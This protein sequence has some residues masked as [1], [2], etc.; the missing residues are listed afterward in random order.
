MMSKEKTRECTANGWSNYLPHCDVRN[1]PPVQV[2]DSVKVLSTSYDEEYSVGQVVRFECKDPSLKLNGP[3]EIYCTSEGEWNLKPPTCA[4][5]SCQSPDI[6]NGELNNQRKKVYK[7]L[8]VMQFTCKRGFRASKNGESTCTK[9]DWNPQPSCTEIVCSRYQTVENGR[10]DGEQTEY[11]FDQEIDV[12]CDAGYVIQQEPNTRRKCTAN[13]WFPPTKCVSKS[14]D[15]P[16]IEHGS[17]Y[18]WYWFPKNNGEYIH[19]RCETNYLPRHWTRIDCTNTGWNP[20]PKCSRLCTYR[21]AFVENAELSNL[22]SEY[23]EGEKVDFQCDDNFITSD[24][25]SKGHRTCLSNGKFTPAKCSRTCKTPEH[26]NAQFT[27]SKKEYEIGEYLQYEC[28]KGYMT[29]SRNLLGRAQCLN[30]RW[31]ETPQCIAITCEHDGVSY[32]DGEVAEFTCPQGQRSKTDFGQCFYY[33]WGP[34]PSCQYIQCTIQKTPG[35]VLSP[36][37]KYYKIYDEVQFSCDQGLTRVGSSRSVCTEKDW[38]QPIPTCEDTEDQAGKNVENPLEPDSIAPTPDPKDK[39]DNG[40]KCPLAYSPKYAEI[41]NPKKAYY[42]ND[43]VTFQCRK[44]YKMFGS[45]TIQCIKGKWEHPPECIQLKPCRNPPA[46]ISD[47]SL[48]D[49]SVREIYVT[50]DVVKYVCKR[51]FHIS[52]SDQSTCINGLWTALPTC[53]ENSCDE[54]PEVINA[55]II[56]KKQ[57]YNHLEKAKY[58]CDSGLSFTGE[59]S[60]LCLEGQWTDTPS[61]VDKSCGPPQVVSNSIIKEQG[62]NRYESGEKV[63]YLCIT[64]YSLVGSGEAF[65]KN[66]V[67]D[68]KPVCKR[69]GSECGPP[70][71]VQYGD[72]LETRKSAYKS[73]ETVTYKCPQYYKL[74][75]ESK[76]KCENGVWDKAPECIEPCTAKEKDMKENN[77]KLRHLSDKKL[78]SE[79]GDVIEFQCVSGFGVP[80]D[81]K[82]RIYC[83][84]GKLE[85]PKCYKRGFCVLQQPTMMANNII[86]NVSTVVD[87]GQTI[88]FQCNEG[89]TAETQLQAKCENQNINYPRCTSAKSCKNPTIQN[90]FIKTAE[91]PR[92]DSGSYVEFECNKDY[93]LYGRMSA[94]CVNGEWEDLP[95]CYAPCKILV[96]KL[97]KH[98]IRLLD[99]M[100][101]MSHTHGTEFRAECRPGFK[102]PV[103][104]A[105]A[106]ECIDGMF[107]YPTCF[108]GPTC[109]M[110]QDQLD[111][112]NLELDE[113]HESAVYYGE[114][115]EIRFKCKAEFKYRGQP[116][117]KCSQ[118]KITYPKCEGESSV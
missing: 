48:A 20:E 29:Q 113:V 24:G 1:C 87:D 72:T 56:E 50:D 115:A 26:P 103:Q 118:K 76:V 99:A 82:M 98:N 11:K 71:H 41:L 92:Y 19:Y 69:T 66:A 16:D 9:N 85:Y 58:I 65:C 53:I 93:V 6:L 61:C 32:K 42:N 68:N 13:G 12:I 97:E 8:E 114:G 100:D 22:K 106:I 104:T 84:R 79:H 14:C 111:E 33:G 7:N 43:R 36:D 73:G 74:Q 116:T 17:L 109:R 23:A 3:P 105:L 89:M 35:L 64:G 96:Q 90:G 62:K 101:K 30:G 27:P 15:K 38:S 47:G 63:S 39:P 31:S 44:G 55:T 108:S 80:T 18:R 117:G 107:R 25:K 60:A 51:G 83:Q 70:P 112:N 49:S 40:L 88:V 78:Y 28:D 45:P 110:D 94:K 81:T 2:E 57:T 77:I 4:E 95:V 91:Q 54:A 21:E 86:Y 67:W 52:G 102:H 10:L 37:R 34:P 75:G 5:I 59:D 46:T